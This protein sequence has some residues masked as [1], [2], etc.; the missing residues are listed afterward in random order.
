MLQCRP[1]E[2]KWNAFLFPHRLQKLNGGN[3]H[4]QKLQSHDS[5]HC[6]MKGKIIFSLLEIESKMKGIK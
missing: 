2:R 1:V 3:F 5:H 4:L 6:R